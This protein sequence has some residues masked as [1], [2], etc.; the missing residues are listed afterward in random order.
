MFLTKK[1]QL[2]QHTIKILDF[3]FL[4]LLNFIESK[5]SSITKKILD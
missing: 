4:K 1:N 2:K 5:I 3:N